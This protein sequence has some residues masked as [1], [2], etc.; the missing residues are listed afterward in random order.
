MITYVHFDERCLD[1]A[2][3]SGLGGTKADFFPSTSGRFASRVV[4]QPVGFDQRLVTAG[5]SQ[6]WDCE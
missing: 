4:A 2:I 6:L 5:E 1:Y 3:S